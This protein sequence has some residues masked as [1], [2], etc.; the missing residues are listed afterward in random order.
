M[1][2]GG[3]GNQ[4]GEGSLGK[5]FYYDFYELDFLR[6]KDTVYSKRMWINNIQGSPESFNSETLSLTDDK[7]SFFVSTYS[8]IND[9]GFV[10]LKKIEIENGVEKYV[11]DSILINTSRLA[12]KVNF[13]RSTKRNK[14]FFYTKEFDDNKFTSNKISF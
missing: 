10:K 9:S 12:N 3:S 13:Y 2:Y 4:T 11:G 5:E 14:F 8:D 6:S 1:L 7:K